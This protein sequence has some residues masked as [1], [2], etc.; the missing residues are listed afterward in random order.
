MDDNDKPVGSIDAGDS[1]PKRSN[2]LLSLGGVM[3]QR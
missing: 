2:M 1:D 3:I